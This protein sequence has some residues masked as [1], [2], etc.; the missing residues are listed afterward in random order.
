MAYDGNG[1]YVRLHNWTQ[2]A[3]NGLDINAS[4]MDG[5]DSGFAAG[6]TLAVTRDG[7]GKMTN[8]FLPNADN[9]LNLGT[10]SRRWLSL[11]G[12][13]ISSLP[14]TQATVGAYFQPQTA[15][16]AAA[17]ITPVNFW[18]VPGNVNRYLTNTTPGTTDMK[19]AFQ[20][21]FNQQQQGGAPVYVPTGSYLIT[22][23]VTTL[24]AAPFVMYGDG[25]GK[26]VITKTGDTD[27]F[28]VINSG[29]AFNSIT[30]RD[31]TLTTS[32]A[33]ATGAAFNLTCTGI[34]PSVTATNVA[35]I[36]GGSNCFAFGFLLTTC[37]DCNFTR[38]FVFTGAATICNAWYVR[39]T[40]V[41]TVY[42]WVACSVYNCAFGVNSNSTTNPG[43][44]GLQFYGCD[45]ITGTAGVFTSNS[46]AAVYGAPQVTWIGGHINTVAGI[47]FNLQGTYQVLIQGAL[48]YNQG[49]SELLAITQCTDINI[50]NNVFE[51]AGGT[52][53]GIVISA[54]LAG[55]NG[56]IIAGN[57][58]RMG[59]SGN[60]VN[61]LSPTLI[62]NLTVQGNQRVGGT[63]M[64][65][66]SGGA[67]DGSIIIQ[68]NTPIDT[69]DLFDTTLTG[70]ATMTLAGIRSD[71]VLI[72]APGGATTCT[73]LTS[74]RFGDK[75]VLSCS[76]ALMTI[77]HNGT[78]PDGFVLQ[79]A[80]NYTFPATGGR[81][82]LQQ[83]NGGCWTE[84]SRDG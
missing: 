38:C 77:Q 58:F 4:E 25:M 33:M 23:S 31:L 54:T 60:C 57:V 47:N 66:S 53:D 12:T 6:L 32:I 83:R 36:T 13:P 71:Y 70:A 7:Q 39:S 15:A 27:A 8:D 55:N 43:I 34:V 9:V 52:A 28:V 20:A 67:L 48:L 63:T 14:V 30:I 62:R 42:K 75:I 65:T 56:G 1:N 59:A 37:G 74:R 72:T 49:A 68:N 19:T 64:F 73:R 40:A 29:S 79:G 76:S 84:V 17:S 10:A 46:Q 18:F 5:E 81:L 78:N 26:S 3:A 45:F 16:E 22:A 35:I 44:E 21:A 82:T 61:L 50:C 41:A 11:N 69:L 80:T 51:T 2:D 24:G